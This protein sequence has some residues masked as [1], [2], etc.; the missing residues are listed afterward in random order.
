MNLNFQLHAILVLLM[1]LNQ[2]VCGIPMKPQI[3]NYIKKVLVRVPIA[4]IVGDC[5]KNDKLCGKCQ[6]HFLDTY[7]ISRAC[8]C[9][10][11]DADDPDHICQLNLQK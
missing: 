5:E 4:F 11:D 1:E 7:Q 3:K 9:H 6:F 10:P 8:T 2:G